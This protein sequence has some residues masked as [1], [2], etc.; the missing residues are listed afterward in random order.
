MTAVQNIYNEY[1]TSVEYGFVDP[2]T[3]IEEMNQRMMDAGLQNIIDEKQA[4]LD[5]WAAANGK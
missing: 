5:E 3:G 1:Q 2:A 4:Q